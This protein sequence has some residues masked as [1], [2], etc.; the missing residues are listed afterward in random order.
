MIGNFR[1]AE[2][3]VVGRAEFLRHMQDRMIFPKTDQIFYKSTQ[4]AVRSALFPVH[5]AD[6][7]VLAVRI[8]IPHLA[9]S[10]FVTTV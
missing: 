4:L 10:Q 8:V 7:I 2:G 5:P 9:V 6:F 1:P 3:F